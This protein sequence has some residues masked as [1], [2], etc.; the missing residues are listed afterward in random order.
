MKILLNFVIS[1]T[2]AK[3]LFSQLIRRLVNV[4]QFDAFKMSVGKGKLSVGLS[5][6]WHE[7]KNK[8]WDNKV[9]SDVVRLR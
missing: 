6:K 8:N 1:E 5:I 7:H 4:V 2:K 9:F 3:T